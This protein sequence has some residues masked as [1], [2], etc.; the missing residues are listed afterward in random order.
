MGVILKICSQHPLWKRS[1]KLFIIP[2]NNKRIRVCA[3]FQIAK[4]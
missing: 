4:Y 2:Y 1:A 3:T